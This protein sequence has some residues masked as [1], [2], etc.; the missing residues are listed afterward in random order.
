MS[1]ENW[2]DTGSKS[3]AKIQH[4]K[5]MSAQNWCDTGSKS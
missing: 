4:S 5:N 1:V 3:S 2:C